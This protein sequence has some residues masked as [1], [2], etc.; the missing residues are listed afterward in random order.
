M[1]VYTFQTPTYILDPIKATAVQFAIKRRAGHE[2][3]LSKTNG[4]P[5]P[6]KRK[7][8]DRSMMNKATTKVY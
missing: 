1:Y 4:K 6:V 2:D 8:G 7:Q 5:S 3:A